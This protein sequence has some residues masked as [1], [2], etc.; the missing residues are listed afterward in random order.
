M[1]KVTSK[2]PV[3]VPKALAERYGI[4]PG[5]E[6]RFEEAG[7]DI[8]VVPLATGPSS[9]G[10]TAPGFPVTTLL[11]S[12]GQCRVLTLSMMRRHL[13]QNLWIYPAYAA[14][15]IDGATPV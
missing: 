3:R 6:L 7:E 13:A 10:R 5:D 15:C 1:S 2:L 14:L 11:E 8:R 4:R 9:A 12:R